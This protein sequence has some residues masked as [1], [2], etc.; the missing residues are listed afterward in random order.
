MKTIPELKKRIAE[1]E[2][3]LNFYKADALRS[4]EKANML[5]DVE[6]GILRAR[7]KE[8]GI[9]DVCDIAEECGVGG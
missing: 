6:I 7:S 4:L 3:E 2:H 8:M 1:L 5:I 9:D